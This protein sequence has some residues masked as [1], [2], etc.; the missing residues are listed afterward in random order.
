MQELEF[1]G[2]YASITGHFMCPWLT[3]EIGSRALLLMALHAAQKV[4]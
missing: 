3:L 4:L 1:R 2:S